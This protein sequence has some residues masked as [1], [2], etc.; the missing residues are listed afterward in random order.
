MEK[1][2]EKQ[3]KTIEDEGEKQVKALENLKPKEQTKA[4]RGKSNNQSRA[5]IIFNGLINKRREIMSELYESVHRN[6]LKYEYVG[7][8]K[9]VRFYE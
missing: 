9:D 6:N 3:V 4:I 5:T 8:T 2:F 7:P 1:A